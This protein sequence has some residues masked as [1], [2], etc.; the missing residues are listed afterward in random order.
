MMVMSDGPDHQAR[1]KI[2]ALGI[3]DD[4]LDHFIPLIEKTVGE[5]IDRAS[6]KGSIEF[7][8]DIAQHIPSIALADLFHIPETERPNFY[9]WSNNMT[10][11]FGGA[12]EYRNEDGVEVNTSAAS[13]R[14]YFVELIKRRRKSPQDDFVSILLRNQTKFG[15]SDGEILSQAVM[16]LVAG[17]VTTSDQM[18]NNLFT[19]L[20]R[21]AA[22]E[23]LRREPALL[24]TALEELNRLDPAVTFIFRVAARDTVLGDQP[25]P[26]GAVLFIS[27]HAVNRDPAVFEKPD[28]CVLSRNPN[29][30]FAFGYGPHFCLGAKLARIE[31]A[32]CFG[33]LLERFPRLALDPNNPSKRKHHSLAFSGFESLPLLL[34]DQA[35]RPLDNISFTA[36]CYA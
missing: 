29:P 15:L 19:L 20:S 10:Q 16:M 28:E 3:D 7:F 23:T 24:K 13:I 31:M 9:K 8:A 12:S 27:A 1:R 30:H 34:S 25:V 2:A 32:A 11:F 35:L 17:Q 6:A 14:G 4:L 26:K 18:C 36:R 33:A 21:P 22:I 5:L